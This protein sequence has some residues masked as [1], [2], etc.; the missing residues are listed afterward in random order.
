M[1]LSMQRYSFNDLNT[2]GGHP[3]VLPYLC[4]VFLDRGVGLFLLFK[5]S[6]M[7]QK[8]FLNPIN[9]LIQT[10]WMT[11]GDGLTPR[12][13]SLR[14][15]KAQCPQP[16]CTGHAFQPYLWTHSSTFTSF[17]NGRAQN[18]TQYTTWGYT[19]TKYTL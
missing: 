2:T 4:V 12:P 8:I 14:T 10:A 13:P 3:T 15:R 6:N 11:W 1:T 7:L 17:L 18:C 9:K 5:Q 19:N 16:L